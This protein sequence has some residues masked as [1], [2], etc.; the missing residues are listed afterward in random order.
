M[1]VTDRPAFIDDDAPYRAALHAM[2]TVVAGIGVDAESS[3]E[4]VSLGERPGRA[5]VVT[6]ST[7]DTFL[8]DDAQHHCYTSSLIAAPTL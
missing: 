1:P 8:L 7:T 6:C 3:K 2:S 4:G 5:R